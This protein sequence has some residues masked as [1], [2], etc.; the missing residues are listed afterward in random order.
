MDNNENNLPESIP[1]EEETPKYFGPVGKERI[2]G[3]IYLIAHI[4]LLPP[5]LNALAAAM[6]EMISVGVAN[7]I[8]YAVGTVFAGF[9]F[10]H[11]LHRDYDG[12]MKIGL[13]IIFFFII[14]YVMYIVL[15]YGAAF[16]L[17]R[18][19]PG[20]GADPNTDGILSLTGRD[21]VMM[22]AVALFIGP[23]LEEILFRGV[24]F[25][26]LVRRSRG[27]AYA[28]SIL[29][30]A[31]YHVWQYVP[32]DPAALVHMINYLP[33]GIVLCWCYEESET[34]WVPILL[35]MIINAVSFAAI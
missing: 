2:A 9:F 30:F 8:Y 15:N 33:A 29:L 21:F 18:F 11:W 31:F 12:L 6:P 20:T 16:A 13:R 35:H 24:V 7:V 28:A 10:L 4:F 19:F 1:P 17:E 22:R 23:V 26:S 27:A 25:G 14:A 3:W 34:L 5:L 32:G